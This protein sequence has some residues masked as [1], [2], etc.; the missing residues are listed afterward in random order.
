MASTSSMEIEGPEFPF[1][2]KQGACRWCRCNLDTGAAVTVFPK[3]LTSSDG[4]DGVYAFKTASGEVVDDHGG[5]A[6]T[7]RGE[8]GAPRRLRGRI[9]DVHKP[10]VAASQT[11]EKD[12]V[13]L[14]TAGGGVILRR[15]HPAAIAM[16]KALKFN[17]Q[18]Y[19]SGITD[20]YQERG[21]YNFYIEL[22]ESKA[23]KDIAPVGEDEEDAQGIFGD[24]AP[25]SPGL[26]EDWEGPGSP[27][28]SRQTQS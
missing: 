7:G 19:P 20:L 21:V 2:V 9:A 16:E 12:N 18:W 24:F 15:W 28:G 3:G 22:Q 11:C 4:K 5:G 27:G 10:L 17:R 26:C 25:N 13:V 1:I 6:L 14:M 8:D 23:K